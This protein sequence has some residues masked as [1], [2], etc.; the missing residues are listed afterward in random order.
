MT[1]KAVSVVHPHQILAKQIHYQ[2]LTTAKAVSVVHP[3]R[4]LA[5]LIH[6]QVL[7]TVKRRHKIV[8]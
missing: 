3:H 5:K 4:V 2:A 6:Y 7:T 1:A 8:A